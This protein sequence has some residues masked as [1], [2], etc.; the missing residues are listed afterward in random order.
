[1]W[2]IW[3]PKSCDSFMWFVVIQWL[4][5]TIVTGWVIC[6][7]IIQAIFESDQLILD[8]DDWLERSD[9]K[10]K[11]NLWFRYILISMTLRRPNQTKWG[12]VKDSIWKS[13]IKIQAPLHHSLE[14]KFILQYE[15][16]IKQKRELFLRV[17]LHL[18]LSDTVSN[19]DSD[20]FLCG[21]ILPLSCFLQYWYGMEAYKSAPFA[22]LYHMLLVWNNESIFFS[23]TALI[24]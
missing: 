1:M 12:W 18:F 13:A 16:D 11:N 10:K 5:F 3:L 24:C 21:Q 20:H 22:W 14:Q 6:E 9:L 17:L 19:N 7:G 15:Y 2:S 8:I 4:S 23:Q